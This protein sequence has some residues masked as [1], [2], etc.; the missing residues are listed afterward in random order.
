MKRLRIGLL[1][2]LLSACADRPVARM[3]NADTLTQRQKD[4]VIGASKLPGSQGIGKAQRA[5][6]R[7]NRRTAVSDSMARADST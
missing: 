5:Q 2:V 7:E 4:S 3:Q 1:C 6:D